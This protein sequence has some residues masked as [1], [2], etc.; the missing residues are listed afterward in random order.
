VYNVQVESTEHVYFQ[1]SPNATSEPSV[2]YGK[3]LK[4]VF[5]TV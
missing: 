5:K 2:A 3:L 4:L 1:A